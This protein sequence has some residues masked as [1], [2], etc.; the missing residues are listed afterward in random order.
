M[1]NVLGMAAGAPFRPHS[2]TPQVRYIGSWGSWGV[3]AAAMYQYQYTSPGPD[4]EGFQYANQ[5]IVPELFL[6]A[7][8]KSDGFIA[9]LGV[10]YLRLR[11]RTESSKVLPD[12][13][14]IPV[15]VNDAFGSFSPTLYAQYSVG[16]FS[17][18]F[19]SLYAQNTGH[20]SMLSGYAAV[21]CDPATG[22][23]V[24]EPMRALV[25]YLD[26]SFGSK[27]RADLF[28]GQM[29][30]FGL[31]NGKEVLHADFANLYMKRAVQN[32][33]SFYRVA[34]SFSY[35]VT[36]FNIGL[37]YEWTGV[38]YGNVLNTASVDGSTIRLVSNH[39]V[40]AMVKYNF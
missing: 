26:L 18:K 7:D 12:G 11:P 29:V 40:C 19:R 31:A 22:S 34:C 38:N 15:R 27:W 2:R 39:R 20:L 17:L 28:L 36:A 25:S 16:L 4:G 3:T 37:E 8:F 10:D 6:G 23:F 5:A 24:Y 13:S 21:D 35:N 14:L 9:Q 33:H 1:P 30:N 32:I